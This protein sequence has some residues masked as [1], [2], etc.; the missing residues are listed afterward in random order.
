M[1]TWMYN[2]RS[3]ELARS[4][5]TEGQIAAYA[6]RRPEVIFFFAELLTPLDI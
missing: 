1:E 3:G 6:Q 5:L 2:S 4:R